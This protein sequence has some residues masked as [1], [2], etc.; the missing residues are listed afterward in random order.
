MRSCTI[1]VS[2]IGLFVVAF[3]FGVAV[4]EDKPQAQPPDAQPAGSVE[5]SGAQ[6]TAAQP[7]GDKQQMSPEQM[8]AE[9]MKV[10]TPGKEHETLKKLAGNWKCEVTMS[11]MPGAT[12]TSQ[13]TNKSEIILADRYLK[14][15][16]QGEMMGMPFKGN[17]LMGFDA[18]KKKY[19]SLWIDEMTTGFMTSEGTADTTGKVITFTGECPEVTGDM[20]PFRHVFTIE[21]DDR[22]TFDA[23]APGPDGKEF[24]MM[25]IVYTR[26]K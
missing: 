4:A 9:W 8:M 6:R 26:E 22:H 13:G 18:M 15:E 10:N 17:G 23:Y 5:K 7:T 11:M 20:K 1:C 25:S 2:L 12:Q 14:S 16:F 3:L 19:V 21:S 24:K